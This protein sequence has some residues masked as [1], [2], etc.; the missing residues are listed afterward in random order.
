MVRRWV[1]ANIIEARQNFTQRTSES[2]FGDPFQS[3]QCR[4]SQPTFD[5]GD[6]LSGVASASGYIVLGKAAFLATASEL[7]SNS[8]RKGAPFLAHERRLSPDQGVL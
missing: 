6:V 5:F 8:Q 2:F 4:V 1:R 3:R 7:P